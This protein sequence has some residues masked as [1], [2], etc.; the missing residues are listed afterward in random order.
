MDAAQ[1]DFQPHRF[2]TTALPERD[3]VA[4]WRDFFGPSV[5]QV[6]IE[7]LSGMPFHANFVA[8]RLPGLTLASS[9][10]SPARFARTPALAARGSGDDIDL[11]I[12]SKGGSAW[13]A[14]R[15]AALQEGE[16]I[17]MHAAEAGRFASAATARSHCLHL[18]V[19]RAGLASLTADLD[20]RMMRPIPAH[21][22]ALRYVASYARFALKE[23]AL[24][25]PELARVAAGHLRDLFALMLGATRD[26]A[27]AAESRGLRAARL[28]AIKSFIAANLDQPWLAVGPV[29]A[30]HGITPRSVQRL[31][32][33]EGMTF[34]EYVLEQRLDFAC[35]KLADP[36]HAHRTVIAVALEAGFGDLSYFNRCFRRRYG[37]PPSWFRPARDTGRRGDN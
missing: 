1:A 36:C 26:A 31:F 18:R 16:A 13:Q 5:F 10:T 12:N 17:L 19:P 14:G 30:H 28:Q 23:P 34:S 35:R 4:M 3:R 27:F 9:V 11:F 29:A 22:E 32:E 20:K 7:P 21:G 33:E 2:T 8:R 25:D 6:E 15:E 37:A 24:A